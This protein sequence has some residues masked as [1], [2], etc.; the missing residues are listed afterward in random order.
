MRLNDR[1]F[2]IFCRAVCLMQKRH[3]IWTFSQLTKYFTTWTFITKRNPL[4][5]ANVT[6]EQE[7]QLARTRATILTS[8]TEY[9]EIRS[10]YDDEMRLFEEKVQRIKTENGCK[11]ILIFMHLRYLNTLQYSFE[12][13]KNF[14]NHS[15]DVKSLQDDMA[16]IEGAFEEISA[17]QSDIKE[18]EET[19]SR[20]QI[21]LLVK[22]SVQRLRIHASLSLLYSTRERNRNMRKSLFD[23]IC[24]IKE[25]LARYDNMDAELMDSCVVA[26]DE[27]FNSLTSTKGHLE[28]ALKLHTTLKKH[29]DDSISSQM[30]LEREIAA[31]KL[32]TGTK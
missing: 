6:P 5:I 4:K 13:M 19:N 28:E 3:S 26:K 17:T 27:Y 10:T 20:L 25:A 29:F 7:Q 23:E 32:A 8:F 18:I 1:G 2:L 12:K 31:S 16:K 21:S 15:G 30:V 14:A 9:E 11:L 24:T 22:L